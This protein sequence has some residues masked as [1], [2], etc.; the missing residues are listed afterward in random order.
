VSTWI[1]LIVVLSRLIVDMSFFT[2]PYARF[3]QPLTGKY[4]EQVLVCLKALYRASFSLHSTYT[5]FLEKKQ[6]IEIFQEIIT[7]TPVLTDDEGDHKEPARNNR[8]Q[9]VWVFNH[10]IQH[11]WLEQ[12]IDETI[13]QSTYTFSRMGRIFTVAMV[14]VAGASFR[15][16]HRNTRNTRNA[17]SSFLEHGEVYDLLDAYEYSERIVTDFTD[18]IDELEET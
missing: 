11:G 15:T 3:F 9:A 16:R 10:L 1:F 6:V 12:R 14:E 2:D 13:L 17:L 4:R 18:V 8:E 7:R 5:Q